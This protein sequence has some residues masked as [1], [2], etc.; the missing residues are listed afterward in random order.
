M[1]PAAVP[2]HEDEISWNC[3]ERYVEYDDKIISEVNSLRCVH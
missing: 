1:H 2:I 3:G